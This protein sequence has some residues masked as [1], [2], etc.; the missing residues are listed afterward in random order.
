MSFVSAAIFKDRTHVLHAAPA[1][2]Q[3]V[4]CQSERNSLDG[5]LPIGWDKLTVEGVTVVRCND[6]LESIEQTHIPQHA[7]PAAPEIERAETPYPLVIDDRGWATVPDP[8]TGTSYSW[9]N[10]RGLR[11]LHWTSPELGTASIQIIGGAGPT[12]G[13]TVAD[14]V[15]T[16][17]TL[18]GVVELRKHLQAIE[19]ELLEGKVDWA[20]KVAAQ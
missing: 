4:D 6:C 12:D 3:C 2:F 9:R 8:E 14:A 16:T 17:L 5:S 7:A 13:E 1:I 18:A 10:Y 15:L 20:Q 19:A 11:V